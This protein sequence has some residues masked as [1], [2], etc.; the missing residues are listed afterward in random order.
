MTN[1]RCRHEYRLEIESERS[2]E[3][4]VFWLDWATTNPGDEV[5]ASAVASN[6]DVDRDAFS[7]VFDAK[8]E[9]ETGV[10]L[11]SGEEVDD[12]LTGRCTKTFGLGLSTPGEIG[13]SFE[14]E[15][16]SRGIRSGCSEE[17]TLAATILGGRL[18][19]IEPWS[20]RT[21]RGRAELEADA[22][23]VGTGEPGNS[24]RLSTLRGPKRSEDGSDCG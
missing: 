16:T 24:A 9:T 18:R 6:D 11:L 1:A 4:A 5:G 19:F 22:L 3:G 23:V 21:D 7:V 14:R 15:T 10:A 2:R 12:M 8:C 17:R 20:R 13:V